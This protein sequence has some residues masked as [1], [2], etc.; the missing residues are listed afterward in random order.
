M[1]SVIILACSY[2]K[3]DNYI[4]HVMDDKK[5]YIRTVLLKDSDY[6]DIFDFGGR[7]IDENFV[8]CIPLNFDE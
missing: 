5:I 7:D 1:D 8:N 4:E 6:M 2:K 3:N